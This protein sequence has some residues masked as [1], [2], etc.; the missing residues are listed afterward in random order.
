[1]AAFIF[2]LQEAFSSLARDVEI[3]YVMFMN[4]LSFGL[5]IS[6][7]KAVLLC[8]SKASNAADFDMYPLYWTN[9]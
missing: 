2:M 4:V 7:G 1:M 3:F 8:K 5:E 9:R 6:K